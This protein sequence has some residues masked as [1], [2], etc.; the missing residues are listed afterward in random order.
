LQSWLIGKARTLAPSL[1]NFPDKLSIPDA[2]F[3]E[4]LV[5]H[6][7]MSSS[8]MCVKLKPESPEAYQ[9]QSDYLHKVEI[10]ME[11]IN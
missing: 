5:R 1:R 10:D 11:T 4:R 6:L 3:G 2:L 7:R 8:D 9:Y